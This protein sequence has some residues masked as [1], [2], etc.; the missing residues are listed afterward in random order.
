MDLPLGKMAPEHFTLDLYNIILLTTE[1]KG[2]AISLYNTVKGMFER[3]IS[4]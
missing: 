3:G 4:S 1:A 2:L